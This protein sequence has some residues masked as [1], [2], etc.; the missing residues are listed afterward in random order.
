MIERLAE[1]S[2][3]ATTFVRLSFGVLIAIGLYLTYAG[4]IA[5]PAVRL[6]GA[7]RAV[8]VDP[9]KNPGFGHGTR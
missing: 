9:V 4:W 2:A 6:V 8:R 1:V 5:K 7:D 3:P